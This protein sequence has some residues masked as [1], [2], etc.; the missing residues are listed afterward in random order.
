MKIYA[1]VRQVIIAMKEKKRLAALLLFWPVFVLIFVLLEQ[2]PI[3]RVYH[4]VWCSLDDVI[5]FCEFFVI[6]YLMW[7]VYLA[8][9]EAWT[10]VHDSAAFVRMLRFIIVTFFITTVIYML[11]PTCQELRPSVMPRKN[12]LTDVIGMLYAMDTSTNVCPSLHVI[13][14]FGI[15]YGLW[16]ANGWRSA[17]M[18]TLNVTLCVLIS[19]S[20]VMIKQHSVVDMLAALPV[21]AVGVMINCF[22][23]KE[24]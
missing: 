18:R 12:L 4:P 21:C 2:L 9:G 16:S 15:C 7:F 3:Q 14:S 19:I 22:F 11:L 23:R 17:G 10:L 13:G 20:T 8:L 24:H 6:P 5:P 1:S